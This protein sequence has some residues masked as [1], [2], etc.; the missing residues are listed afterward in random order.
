MDTFRISD[1]SILN[2]ICNALDDN[3]EILDKIFEASK[4]KEIHTLQ[5]FMNGIE[6]PNVVKTL[7]HYLT[8]ANDEL[9]RMVEERLNQKLAGTE[10][11]ELFSEMSNLEWKI[12]E[13]LKKTQ[14]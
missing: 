5:L 12:K 8:Y 2:I 4:D 13:F 7:E 1:E 3:D 10:L 9:D 6:V 14:E 11:Q